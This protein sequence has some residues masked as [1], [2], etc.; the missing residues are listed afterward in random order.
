MIWRSLLIFVLC[1]ATALLC[2]F[3]ASARGGDDSGVISQLPFVA[4]SFVGSEEKASEME[5]KLLPADS[6]L[7]KRAYR[8]AAANDTLH[9]SLV[10]AGQDT[11]AIHR[12]EV[13]LPGQGWTITSSTVRPIE[14]KNGTTLHVRDLALEKLDQRTEGK[15]RLIRAHYIYWFVGKGVTTTSDFARQWLSFKDSVFSG[16]NH[17][18][19][20]PSAMAFVTQ[21]MDPRKT[22]ERPRDDA[23]TLRMLLSFI[24]DITPKFQKDLATGTP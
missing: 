1:A 7:I 22:G 6:T 2:H 17:R 24:R 12:P 14:M 5:I 13:C 16:I 11:R 19:A 15:K 20:Y 10:I 4:G 3:S 23:E 9:V 8:D 21:G 18:W